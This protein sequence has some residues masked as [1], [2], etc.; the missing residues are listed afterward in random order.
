M[1]KHIISLT[2]MPGAGKSA[3]A[4]RVAATLGY[5]HFS[6]GDLF[7]SIGAERG[8][9]VSE[10]N[11]AAE[12]RSEIDKMVD[13]HSVAIG[14][15]EDNVVIDSRLAFH[16]I[17]QSFK[18]FLKLDP[19]VAASRILKQLQEEGRINQTASSLEEVEADT[20]LRF[21]SE[22]KRYTKL[23]NVDYTDISQFDLV[24]DTAVHPLEKVTDIIIEKYQEWLDR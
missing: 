10:T 5:R 21:K 13:A 12:T 22:R 23:Y 2:G 7:R 24:V 4:K 1:K 15:T 16:F 6:T 18:I 11:I 3:T 19:K 17:P 8:L 9:S 14:E 20:D